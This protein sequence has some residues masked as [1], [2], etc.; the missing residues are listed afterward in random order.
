MQYQTAKLLIQRNMEQNQS[1]LSLFIM[2][3]Y[4]PKH[5]IEGTQRPRKIAWSLCPEKN[6]TSE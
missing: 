6:R 1:F 2:R 4:I 3:K 5:R